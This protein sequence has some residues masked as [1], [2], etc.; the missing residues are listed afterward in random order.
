MF[1]IV[2]TSILCGVVLFVQVVHYPMFIDYAR[3]H[4]SEAMKKHQRLTSWVVVPL[5]LA[6]ILLAVG[7]FATNMYYYFSLVLLAAVWF[8]T[9]LL[10]VPCHKRLSLG[11][12][13]ETYTR[14][15]KTNRY[16]TLAW[17]SRLICLGAALG[18]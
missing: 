1:Q 4:F 10:Q 6:E 7:G 11:W 3:D 9:F 15:V 12:N 16:R 8:S 17:F 18:I 2:V 14:L 13:E 5:M